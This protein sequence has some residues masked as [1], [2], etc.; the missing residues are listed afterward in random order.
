ME[1]ETANR[2]KLKLGEVV[3]QVLQKQQRNNLEKKRKGSIFSESNNHNSMEIN[4]RVLS[5]HKEENLS[6]LQ[7]P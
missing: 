7:R 6:W 1:N 2:R 3:C 5:I 4:E